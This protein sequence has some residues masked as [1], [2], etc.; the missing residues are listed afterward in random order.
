MS[1]PIQLPFEKFSEPGLYLLF[2]DGMKQR[3][4]K[5]PQLLPPSVRAAPAYAPCSV[6]PERDTALICHAIP[7]V[8]PFI[9]DMDRFLSHETVL[10]VFRPAPCDTSDDSSVLHVS[11]TSVQRA[12]QYVSIMSLIDYCEVGRTYF[13]Y[14][15]GIIPL[16]DPLTII[17]RIY[18][19]IYWDLRGD[20]PAIDA[21]M[22]KMRT[23]LDITVQCQLERLRLFCQSDVFPNAFV[24]THIVTQLLNAD[25]ET[26]VQERFAARIAP[27]VK[28]D[29]L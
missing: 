26:F 16:M 6:C 21:L 24:I 2:D 17:E 23:E 9:E 22:V 4:L 15:S 8:F 18:L 3:Y 5:D 10:A 14:F 20:L 28:A 12:L 11:R 13:K 19:S 29:S 1:P 25:M 7:T 27:E